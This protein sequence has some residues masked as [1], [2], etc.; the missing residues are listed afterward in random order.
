MMSDK[1]D[2]LLFTISLKSPIN[3]VSHLIVSAR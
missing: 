2:P 1:L 3:I